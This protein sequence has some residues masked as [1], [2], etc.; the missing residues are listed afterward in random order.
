[1]HR[2]LSIL[3]IGFALAVAMIAA[4]S[5]QV[6]D[7]CQLSPN[8]IAD[9][10]QMLTAPDN[11]LFDKWTTEEQACACIWLYYNDPPDADF[12]RRVIL[13]AIVLLGKT[14][15]SRAV[16]VLI[17]AIPNYGPQALYALANFPTV[18]ALNA[19]TANVTNPDDES[20]ENAAEGLR[21]MV[22]P[23]PSY[24]PDGWSD[25]LQAAIKAV[26]DWL[27]NEKEPTFR[28]Y[29]TDAE[30]HLTDLLSQVTTAG[31]H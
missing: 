31:T 25:A 20:R 10:R 2:L 6:P 8:T 24:I 5:A 1:M 19:L 3:T 23:N 4:A 12:H 11:G 18:D 22:P 27:P 21:N 14:G 13:G 15:D 26:D 28:D 17:D 29:F 9:I 30:N 7:N 16:P